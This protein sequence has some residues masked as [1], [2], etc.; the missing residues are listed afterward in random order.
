M[1]TQKP[2]SFFYKAEYSS[3]NWTAQL[4]D[5]FSEKIF[6]NPK[7]INLIKDFLIIWGHKESL[8]LDFTAWSW[9]AWHAVLDLNKEDWWNR[10]FILCTN[11]ENN[12]CEDITYERI[13]RVSNWY[14]NS[15]WKEIEWL[16]WNL[17]YYKTEFV[18]VESLKEITDQ[19]K[20]ELTYNAW[21]L[22]AIKE[23]IYNE[24][25]KNNYWQIFESNK[26]IVAVYFK[27]SARKVDEMKERLK[28]I[29]KQKKWKIKWYIY[30]NPYEKT[31]FK[32]MKKTELLDIPD[33]I[34]KVYREINKV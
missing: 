34:L 17:R 15:K 13:K 24:L 18:E 22:L 32:D 1:P 6:N 30:N 23:W 21:E 29:Q 28:D 9:T 7:P 11:N 25:E 2:K 10:K 5:I 3:W 33:P 27:E 20:L 26:D 14:K 19:K 31:M 12:I 4:K 8:V 16:W